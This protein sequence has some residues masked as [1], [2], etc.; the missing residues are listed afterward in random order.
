MQMTADDYQLVVRF[1]SRS[2]SL[3][4]PTRRGLAAKIADRIFKETLHPRTG[5][6]DTEALLAKVASA[7]REK[8]R[9]L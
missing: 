3:D 7:Y 6:S 4:V 8:T 5:K 9:I 2:A 1:L